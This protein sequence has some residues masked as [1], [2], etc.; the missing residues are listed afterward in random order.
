MINDEA[1]DPMKINPAPNPGEPLV[2]T[3]KLDPNGVKAMAELDA[4]PKDTGVFATF[5][6]AANAFFRDMME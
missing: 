5:E 2:D 3:Y 6:E 1:Y 4:R